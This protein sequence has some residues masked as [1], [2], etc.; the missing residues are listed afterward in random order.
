MFDLSTRESF[1]TIDGLLEGI[2]ENVDKSAKI[3]LCGNKKDLDRKVTTEEAR[4]FAE[5]ESLGY[6]ET[7]IKDNINVN[8]GME[9]IVK[10]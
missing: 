9:M 8:E 6:I 10:C 2:R 7:S 3:L 4:A 1:L 5:K